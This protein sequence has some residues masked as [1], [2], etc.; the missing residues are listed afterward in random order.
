MVMVLM[1]PVARALAPTEGVLVVILMR[2]VS[3]ADPYGPD[4]E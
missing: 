4:D 3:L 2:V 1:T